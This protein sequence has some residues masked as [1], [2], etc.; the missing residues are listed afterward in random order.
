MKDT[1]LKSFYS[2]MLAPCPYI[3]GR[4]ESKLAVDISGAFASDWNNLLSR[5]GFRRSHSV[6][7]IPACPNCSECISVRIPVAEFQPSKKM[8]KVLRI[9]E[10]AKIAF[11]PNIATTEQFDLFAAYLLCRHAESDMTQMYYEEY[12]AMIED[13]NVDSVLMEVREN[14]TLQAAMLVDVLDD[15]LSAVYSFFDPKQRRRSLGTFMILKLIE[16]ARKI[17]LLYVYPGYW[18]KSVSNMAYKA[19]FQPLEYFVNGM[20]TRSLPD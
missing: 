6:C 18:I 3:A 16:E 11:T 9:N 14:A 13:A 2:S 7:Y 17:G 20:W 4:E 5:A 15:G 10:N 8:R 19:K 1:G 12:R